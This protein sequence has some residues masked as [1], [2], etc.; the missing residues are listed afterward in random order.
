MAA[1]PVDPKMSKVIISAQEYHCLEEVLTIMS[2]LSTESVLINPHSKREEALAARQKFLSS[3]G[4]HITLL[5]VFRA[6]KGVNG[7]KQWCQENYINMRNMRSCFDVRRQLR[8]ICVR[9][10]LDMQSCG[11]ETSK[12]RKCICTGFFM[13]SSEL[14]K[15]GEYVTLSS[16]K[17]V[18]IHPSSS[19][20]H[21]KP[22]YVLYN[23]LVQT[24]KCYMRDLCVVDADWLYEIAPTYF[25]KKKPGG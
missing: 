3:E 13:N 25:K 22:A 24:T 5:N 10:K 11:Q 15:E 21:C 9:Q 12:L 20:F 23:E 1:F 2:M 4:D 8:D 19:L 17:A 14:Q 6:Y 18:T 7:N 16:R